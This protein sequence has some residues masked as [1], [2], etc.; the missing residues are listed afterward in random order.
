[1]NEKAIWKWS[2]KWRSWEEMH[3]D[4]IDVPSFQIDRV[5][6]AVGIVDSRSNA[7]RLIKGGG[8]TWRVDDDRMEWERVKDFKQEIEPG[9]PVILR[10]GDG[11]VRSILVE[12]PGLDGK[13]VSKPKQMFSLATVM[14]PMWSEGVEEDGTPWRVFQSRDVWDGVWRPEKMS[15]AELAA[16]EWTHEFM[17]PEEHKEFL[18][19]CAECEKRRAA[20]ASV[21]ELAD[22]LVRETSG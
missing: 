3:W 13:P 11:H 19:E 4:E 15:V 10:I 9:W 17:S 2:T 14:R 7:Q 5:L 16:W 8:V 20:D 12:V 1:M 6:V 21:A 18:A 22:A